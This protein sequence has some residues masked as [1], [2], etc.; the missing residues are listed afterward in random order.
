[1]GQTGLDYVPS[2]AGGRI[3]QKAAEFGGAG[4]LGGPEAIPFAALG[5][6]A[7]QGGQ[8]LGLPDWF[9]T[10]LGI[11]APFLAHTAGGT[12][13]L[14]RRPT[15][16]AGQEAGAGQVIRENMDN[17]N[18]PFQQTPIPAAFWPK[19]E[20]RQTAGQAFGDPTLQSFEQ[21]R[22]QSSPEMRTQFEKIEQA[23]NQAGTNVLNTVGNFPNRAEAGPQS[24]TASS[25]MQT[26]TQDAS[27]AAD[28]AEHAAWQS[29]DPTNSTAFD[30]LGLK[31]KVN[32]YANGTAPG[33]SGRT[34]SKAAQEYL[35]TTTLDI[36]NN[37]L[38]PTEP[39]MEFQDLRSTLSKKARGLRVSGTQDNE[40]NVVE[41]LRDV[42]ANHIDNMTMPTPALATNYE[43][44]RL[45]TQQLHQTFDDKLVQRVLNSPTGSTTAG[46][47]FM[48]S[49][50]GFNAYIK[51]TGGSP[52]AI[53]H[54]QDYFLAGLARKSLGT[55]DQ[56]AAD[57]Y[58]SYLNRPINQTLLNDRR[59]FTQEQADQ[60]NQVA[61]QLDHTAQTGRAG[62]GMGGSQTYR[63]LASGEQAQALVGKPAQ[64]AANIATKLKEGG[65]AWIG[66]HF[67]GWPGALG[68]WAV[69][70]LIPGFSY[71]QAGQK[72]L[73][74]VDKALADP[75][76]AERL[77]QTRLPNPYANWTPAIKASTVPILLGGGQNLQGPR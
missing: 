51:A 10:T 69:S 50:E 24:L 20:A 15:T 40:A 27:D 5:G 62:A 17:P 75:A 28:A 57:S 8:E 13:N 47:T 7:Q 6:A 55:G 1:V 26:V 45:L 60:I 53:Q 21:G 49:P 44:A 39:L 63:Q 73:N 3:A 74:L 16:T 76:L 58:T 56:L 72:V 77:R 43:N 48:S 37:K 11:T 9:N 4:I 64:V 32:N 23:T 12:I 38:G 52:E 22:F 35:P 66:H 36:I 59:L 42:V 61:A 65:A 54:A 67:G 18:A 41:G 30:T 29:A 46:A 25:G 70:H 19:G 68:G 2:T 34:L 33:P 14:L 31:Q 71:E